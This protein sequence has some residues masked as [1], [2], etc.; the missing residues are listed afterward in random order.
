MVT[1][2][3]SAT[4]PY[5]AASLPLPSPAQTPRRAPD[6][7]QQ[8]ERVL[9][10]RDPGLLL[11]GLGQDTSAFNGETGRAA[12]ENHQ[13]PL[14]GNACYPGYGSGDFAGKACDLSFWVALTYPAADQ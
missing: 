9:A 10:A 7:R 8:S 13:N 6:Q 11:T 1:P 4:D 12:L 5:C 2:T 3:S 14:G